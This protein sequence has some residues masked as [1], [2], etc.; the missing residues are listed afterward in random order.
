MFG[1]MPEDIRVAVS[2]L[3]L[4]QELTDRVAPFKPHTVRT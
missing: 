1:G 4:R 3:S 2:A